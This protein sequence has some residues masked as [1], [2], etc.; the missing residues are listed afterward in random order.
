M[1]IERVLAL[2]NSYSIYIVGGLGLLIFVLLIGSLR[3]KSKLNKLQKRFE[4]F[5]SKDDI[6]LEGLLVQYTKH[7]NELVESNNEVRA[8]MQQVE[9]DL[10][11]CV[12][13]VGIVRYQAIAHTGADLSFA[14]ALLNKQNDGIVLN[15]IYSRDGSYTYAKPIKDG[16][17]TYN[18][19]DE[20]I[21]ALEQA[22][23]KEAAVVE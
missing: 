10:N 22:M 8:V 17:S 6:D 3:T 9:T 23:S 13:K 1:T 12:Q 11:D 4:K 5:M 14:I 21:Q 18:L 2:Y 19:S 16:K 20:E 15:G 7:I